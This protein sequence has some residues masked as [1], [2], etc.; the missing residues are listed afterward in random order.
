[1]EEK[2]TFPA[3][4]DS[5]RHSMRYLLALLLG[6]ALL[7]APVAGFAITKEDI[8]QLSKLGISKDEIIKAIKKDKTVFKLPV[9]EILRLKKS[10]VHQEVIKFML[11]TPRMFGSGPAK[12]NGAPSP[13]AAPAPPVSQEMTA[14]QKAAEEDRLRREAQRLAE[15]ARRAEEVQKAAYAKGIFREGKVQ[16]DA[17]NFAEAIRIF[18]SFL[19]KGA[20]GPGTKEYVVARF[21][22]ANALIKAGLYQ[23]AAEILMEVLLVGPETDFFKTA[24]QNLRE[25]RRRV[26]WGPPEIERLTE[27]SVS[28]FSQ[29][30]QDEYHYVLGE[31]FFDAGN[32]ERALP[33]FERVSED[34]PDHARG[35]YLTALVQVQNQMYRSSVKSLERAIGSA[36][37][38]GTDRTVVELCYMALAR[39]AY[40]NNDFY[41]AVYYYRKIP[42]SSNRAPAAFFESAWAYFLNA[43]YVRALGMFHALHSPAFEHFFYPELWILEATVYLN[44]CH[45]KKAR[46][47]LEM[48]TKEVA[49]LAPRLKDFLRTAQ[50][51][52]KTYTAAI[53]TVRGDKTYGLPPV[54]AKPL[55]ADVDFHNLYRTIRQIEKEEAD[56]KLEQVKLGDLAKS[57]LS[58]LAVARQN[59]VVRAGIRAQRVLRQLAGELDRYSINVTEIE[60]DLSDI[61][62]MEIDEETRRLV[63]QEATEAEEVQAEAQ[64]S[65][66]IVG[67]DSMAWPF[68]GEY[69]LD[70]I[71]YYRAMVP[72]RCTE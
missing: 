40:A 11:E 12:Q 57:L 18:R 21:G 23:S 20:Y 70:E 68:E 2:N 66:A 16:A 45:Y 36:E 28:A 19:E 55:L 53:A 25:L 27:I 13:T 59:T 10:G 30:F 15:E 37:R 64:Q 32:F 42:V 8:V 49:A 65:L 58:R 52:M 17:G 61:E 3:R 47:A 6:V 34:S 1:M 5:K 51:P 26:V 44:T 43:D 39:I 31:F 33:Y 69:W 67:A 14:E 46:A 29:S 48:F 71:P 9:Q 54:L 41:A 60:V 35:L 63:E 4:R 50:N 7:V 22:I 62:I 56:L 72:D 24:F 38:T